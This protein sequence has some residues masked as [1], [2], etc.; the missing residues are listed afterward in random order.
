MIRPA[1]LRRSLA[2]LIVCSVVGPVR[3]QMERETYK[4]LKVLPKD[5]SE[6][7][8]DATMRS[9]TRGLGV[10]CTYCHVG[11]EGKPM[12]HEDFAKDDKPTKLKA[13]EMMRMMNDINGNYLAHLDSRSNPPVNVQC[14]TCHRGATKPRMLQDVLHDAYTDGGIDST[15]QKYHTLRDRYY[16]RFTY[17]FGEVPLTELANQVR[18]QGHPA[19]AVKLLSFNVEMNPASMFAKRQLADNAIE[20]SFVDAGPD[21][22]AATYHAM[23][24]QFG[25]QLV[26]EDMLNQIG[27]DLLG[28]KQPAKAVAVF[29]LNANEHPRSGNAFD[30]LGEGYAAAGD[31]KRAATA[32]EKALALD[33]S[34]DHAK[35]ALADLKTRKG[36]H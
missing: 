5:V 17:D 29:K 30:S 13:R 26:N 4:N 21:S 22:G 8:L 18:Q 6:E 31:T 27:Y 24:Q 16:G 1:V 7:V 32:Y 2:V 33:P 23:V 34:N 9:F 28:Q 11:E 25:P 3:A 35:T 10:R 19:D 15:L 14:V 36:K 12:R 20:Q